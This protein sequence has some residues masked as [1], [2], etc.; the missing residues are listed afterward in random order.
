L[1]FRT[2]RGIL[3][4]VERRSHGGRIETGD[5][6]RKGAKALRS[7]GKNKGGWRSTTILL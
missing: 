4:F 1:T 6:L 5:I 7:K 3:A 2:G